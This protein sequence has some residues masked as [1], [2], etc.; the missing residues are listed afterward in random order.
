M[1]TLTVVSTGS[2]GKQPLSTFT[3]FTVSKFNLLFKAFNGF[4]PEFFTLKVDGEL[5]YHFAYSAHVQNTLLP[6][7]EPSD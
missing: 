2:V 1:V 4:F 6:L 5:P 7:L 3:R